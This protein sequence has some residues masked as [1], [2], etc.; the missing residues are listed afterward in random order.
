MIE[1]KK[2]EERLFVLK[3]SLSEIF[4]KSE[5]IIE[6]CIFVDCTK[7]KLNNALL[8]FVILYMKLRKRKFCYRI[9]RCQS[10]F[11]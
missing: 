1:K 5:I 8:L 9:F 7:K 10:L 11:S 4:L 2:I 6:K 3:I